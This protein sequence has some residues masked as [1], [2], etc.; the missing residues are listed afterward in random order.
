[1]AALIAIL[2]ASPSP[3]FQILCIFCLCLY[4]SSTCQVSHATG[5]ESVLTSSMSNA[6]DTSVPYM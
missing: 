4:R 2:F 1:M 5:N 3:Y 6:R